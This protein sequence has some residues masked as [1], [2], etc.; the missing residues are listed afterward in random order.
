MMCSGDRNCVLEEFH[1][2]GYYSSAVVINIS[3]VRV[4]LPPQ[5][6]VATFIEVDR[7][8]V[9]HRIFESLRSITIPNI[10]YLHPLEI[11]VY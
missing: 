9:I 6:E 2:W 1:V 5:Q 3:T 8:I 10:E 11:N 4:S 7:P